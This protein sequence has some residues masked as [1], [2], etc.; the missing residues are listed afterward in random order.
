[1]GASWLCEDSEDIG[2][3]ATLKNQTTKHSSYLKLICEPPYI[4]PLILEAVQGRRL[5]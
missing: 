4:V 1:M 3:E 2:N 5:A